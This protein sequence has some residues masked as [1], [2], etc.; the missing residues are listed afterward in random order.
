MHRR[1]EEYD[2]RLCTMEAATPSAN[3]IASVR[4]INQCICA[5]FRCLE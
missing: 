1:T 5:A 3:A 4:L 2:A